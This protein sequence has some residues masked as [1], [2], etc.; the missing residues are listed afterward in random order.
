MR[1]HSV[2]VCDDRID[3]VLEV[4][5]TEPLR[6][7]HDDGIAHRALELMPGLGRHRCENGQGRGFADELASTELPHLFEHVVLELMASA[8]SPRELRGETA[9]DFAR[10]G[11]GVFR[12]SVEYDDDLVG[13]GAVKAAGRVMSYLLAGGEPPDL[14]A[15]TSRLKA[16]RDRTRT[17]A[18]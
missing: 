6:T 5:E 13:L 10:D 12:V 2:T 16:V 1:V 14:E 4:S 18:C 15:E 7:R 11:R 17:Y 9:W 3:V 8:G